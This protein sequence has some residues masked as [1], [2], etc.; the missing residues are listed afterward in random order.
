MINL[1]GKKIDMI[2]QLTVSELC[3][4]NSILN[5]YRKEVN[6]EISKVESKYKEEIFK[7]GTTIQDL[8]NEQYKIVEDKYEVVIREFDNSM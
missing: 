8:K 4:L 5:N 1:N 6:D 2:S 7:L 3:E